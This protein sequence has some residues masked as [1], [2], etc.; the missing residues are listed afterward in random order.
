MGRFRHTLRVAVEKEIIPLNFKGGDFLLTVAATKHGLRS[1]LD[2]LKTM[3][4]G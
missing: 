3:I 2:T 1:A 4:P